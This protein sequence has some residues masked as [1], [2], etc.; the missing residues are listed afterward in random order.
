M[1][2]KNDTLT[3]SD[4]PFHCT[5]IDLLRSLGFIRHFFWILNTCSDGADAQTD[6]S[7][8]GAR[9]TDFPVYRHNLNKILKYF[10]I[11]GYYNRFLTSLISKRVYKMILLIRNFRENFIS[12][13]ALKDFCHA[14]I[15][16]TKVSYLN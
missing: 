14:K 9:L 2:I 11:A 8:A 3:Q 1:S 12:R 5:F 16:A 15:F 6:L 7:F 13:I 10:K 4:Q